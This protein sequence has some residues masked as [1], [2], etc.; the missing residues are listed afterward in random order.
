MALKTLHF[1]CP[2]VDIIMHAFSDILYMYIYMHYACVY[3]N[4]F[5]AK[6]AS[7][8]LLSIY[9][10]RKQIYVLYIIYIFYRHLDT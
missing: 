5:Y 9:T 3:Y 6:Q 10:Y 7:I 8:T 4:A 1:L 2:A